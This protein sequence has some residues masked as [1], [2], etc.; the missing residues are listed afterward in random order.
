MARGAVD[1]PPPLCDV[2]AMRR[3]LGLVLWVT[4]CGEEGTTTQTPGNLSCVPLVGDD[5]L[6]PFPSIFFEK[7]D[8]TSPTGYRVA[9]DPDKMPR[10]TGGVALSPDRLN[11]KDGFSGSSPFLVYF[12]DG[13]DQTQLPALADVATTVTAASTVQVLEFTSGERVPVYAEV[14]WWAQGATARQALI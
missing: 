6:T 13:V 2:R 9:L 3:W 7:V 12:K 4:A 10:S 14:D 8:A 11:Q 1:F 5:C